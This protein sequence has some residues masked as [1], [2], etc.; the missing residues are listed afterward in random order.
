METLFFY[1]LETSGGSVSAQRIMQFAGQRTKLDLE[2]IGEPVNVLIKLDKEVLPDP[3]AIFIHGITPQEAQAKGMSEAD[4][5]KTVFSDILTPYTTVLG[6]NN[7]RFDDRLIQHGLWRNFFDPYTWQWQDQRSRWDLLDAFRMARVLRPEGI[8]WPFKEDDKPINRLESL[9][10]ANQIEHDAHDALGDVFATIELARKLKSAQPK[11]FDWSYKVRQKV[12][13]NKLVD[14]K[15]PQPFI[16]TSGR[17]SSDYLSTTIAWPLLPVPERSGPTLVWD[18]RFDVKEFLDLS[19]EELGQRAFTPRRYLEQKSPLPV[20]E[21]ANNRCPAIAPLSILNSEIAGRINLTKKE[22]EEHA[23]G[24]LEHPELADRILEVWKNKKAYS[25]S[26]E[27]EQQLYDDLPPNEDRSVIDEVRRK[28]AEEFSSFKPNFADERYFELLFRYK[29][30][31]FPDSLTPVEQK[32]WNDYQKNRLQNGLPGQLSIDKFVKKLDRLKD[33]SNP[34]L[35]QRLTDY[36][37]Y[38]RSELL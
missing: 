13:I 14:P 7:L 31:N 38:L 6:F 19:V 1:D 23:K 30:R 28:K 12:E 17:Y 33:T 25:K 11:L 3:E 32:K 21:L 29:A 9:A 24:L 4:F 10:K 22:A 18:L 5:F 2:P 16:Y 20:K 37:A 35:V 34:K 8:E 15:K 26:K 27:V 36:I